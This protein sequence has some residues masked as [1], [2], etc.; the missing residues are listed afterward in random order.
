MF[1]Y[2]H[3]LN[4]VPTEL[5]QW[6]LELLLWHMK[7]FYD[8]LEHRMQ[9]IYLCIWTP[10]ACIQITNIRFSSKLS[11]TENWLDI[12]PYRVMIPW[13]QCIVNVQQNAQK[14]NTHISYAD[15]LGCISLGCF[16]RF[17][18]YKLKQKLLFM[19]CKTCPSSILQVG[20]NYSRSRLSV[21]ILHFL[22]FNTFKSNSHTN[23]FLNL[24]TSKTVQ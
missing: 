17:M 8:A 16:E 7:V 20:K 23:I 11:L 3:K 6:T 15:Y 9:F 24:S 22:Q 10:D 13:Q 19:C 5:L 21:Y 18:L 4:F 2:V 12:N 1:I 14:Q